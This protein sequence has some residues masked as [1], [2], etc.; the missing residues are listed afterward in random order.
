MI[1]SLIRRLRARVR[2]GRLDDEL[3]DEIRMHLDMRAG[4]DRPGRR[5]A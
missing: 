1:G 4:A 5:S 3:A 2:R